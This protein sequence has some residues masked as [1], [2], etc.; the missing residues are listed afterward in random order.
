MVVGGQ[1][2]GG[3][4]DEAIAVQVG[5]SR[6]VQ[7]IVCDERGKAWELRHQHVQHLAE[8][9]C[10]DF[11]FRDAGPLAGD[12]EKLNVHGLKLRNAIP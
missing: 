4:A 2:G 1:G 5:G 3:I 6:R 7:P 12:A 10:L 9:V 8:R 11:Q